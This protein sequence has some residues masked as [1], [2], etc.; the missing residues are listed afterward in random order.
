[1]SDEKK[2][3]EA[4]KRKH[5]LGDGPVV[6]EYHRKMLE[7]C[8]HLDDVFNGPDRSKPK[9][10]GFVLMVFPYG[11]Q[12]TAGRC[13]YMSNGANRDDVVALM[14]EMIRRFD[15]IKS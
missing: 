2:Q 8:N 6:A 12:P 7:I 5:Q 4:L 13:N 15:E 3:F 10:T 14:R 1:M 9:Q 11:E